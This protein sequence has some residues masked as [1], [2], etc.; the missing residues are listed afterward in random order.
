[1]KI[2]D[3][4]AFPLYD[5]ALEQDACGVGFV[6]HLDGSQS[7]EPLRE[8][9]FAL[10]HLEH[11]GARDAD[12]K[13]GDGAGVMFQVPQAFFRDEYRRLTGDD[14]GVHRMAVG[15]CFLPDAGTRS[16]SRSKAVIKQT[17]IDHG[18]S[19]FVW[20]TVPI[21]HDLL[22]DRAM[23]TL[24]EIEQVLL[25]IEP[26]LE[27]SDVERR[28]FLLRRDIESRLN[29]ARLQ[30][31]YIAS[32]SSRTIIYK[33]MLSASSLGDFYTDLRNGRMVSAFAI[34]HQRYSTNT[35]PSWSL[36]QPFRRVAHNGEINTLSGNRL[37]TKVRSA[38]LTGSSWHR[39][40]DLLDPILPEQTSDSANLDAILELM[41]LSER[42]L[43][44]SLAMLMPS[45][46]ESR[47][48]WPEDVRAFYQYHACIME[49]WD[50]PAA[51][52]FG[53]GKFVGACLDRHGLRP[54]R[55]KITHDNLIVLGSEVGLLDTHESRVVERGRL[56]P[57][58]MVVLDVTHG[59][60]YFDKDVKDTLAAARPYKAWL[61]AR[62]VHLDDV[63]SEKVSLLASVDAQD[64]TAR[65]AAFG[66]S[67]EEAKFIFEPMAIEGKEPVGSMG[68][69]TPLSILSH[70]PRVL[71][72]YVRQRFAQVTNPPIDS[73]RERS[74]MSLDVVIGPQLDWLAVDPEHARK[75]ILPSPFL[76]DRSLG[77]ITAH[78]A[79]AVSILET[80]FGLEESLDH[81]LIA[82]CQ[83]AQDRVLSG[84]K[85]LIL[86]DRHLV[87][88]HHVPIPPLLAIGAVHHHLCRAKL[89][90]KVSLIVQSGEPRD[91]HHM[92][93][94]LGF[95][96]SAVHPYL[97]HEI[98]AHQLS[99]EEH[100]PDALITT[101]NQVLDKGL[102]KVMAKMGISTL[103]SYC[104]AQ[105]FEIIGLSHDVVERCFTGAP[106]VLGGLAFE[107]IEQDARRRHGAGFEQENKRLQDQGMY[108]FRRGGE[109][110][111]WSPQMLKAIKKF[112]ASL[113]QEDYDHYAQAATQGPPNA[114]R[115]LLVWKRGI[116]AVPL[117]DVESVDAICA[118]FT[119]AAMSLGSLSPEAHRTLVRAMN[120]IGG[121]SNTGEGGEDPAYYSDGPRDAIARIK[122]IASGRFGVTTQYLM[123]AEEIEIK[124]AQGSKPGE[125]GQIP[126]HKVS[127]YIAGLRRSVP[128]QPLISPPPH[129]DIYSIED[130]AQLIDDLRQVNPG[131]RIGVKL[132]AERG[133]G[134][135]AAGVAKAGADVILISGHEGGTGASPLSSIK[136]AGSPWELGL[137]ET[138]QI[139][140]RNNLRGRVL[141]RTDGGLKTGRD[142]VI[143]ALLGAEEY[144]FGTAALVALGCRYVRQC[145]SNTCPVGIATQRE[146]L[147]E[148][149]D[150]D[151]DQLVAFLRS[152]AEHVRQILAYMGK[153]S[154]QEIIGRTDLLR[155]RPD[156]EHE[157]AALLD[158]KVLMP[159]PTKHQVIRRDPNYERFS[160][161]TLNER[162]VRDMAQAVDQARPAHAMYDIRN[163]DRT[164]GATLA[165]VIASRYG[166]T[167]TPGTI[168][169]TFKGC[170][171]QSFGAF[172]T[173][174]VRL[175][176]RGEAN[177]YVGKGMNGGEIIVG[178]NRPQHGEASPMLA[179][180]TILYG[181]TGGR[182]F[183][184]GRVGERF[185]VR[186]SG[187]MAVVEGVGAHACEYMTRG[188][189]A[190]LGPVGENFGAGMTG[191]MAYVL[192]ASDDLQ[193]SIHPDFVRMDA[194]SA[195]DE[196]ALFEM[197]SRHVHVTNSTR[198]KAILEDWAS[199][200]T[201]FCKISPVG[202]PDSLPLTI[203]PSRIVA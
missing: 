171:G 124:M 90:H 34:F 87:D 41:A 59:K 155:A 9:L 113:A 133:V 72:T 18:F 109:R 98:I 160:E 181:A 147:R 199:Y 111:G 70:L 44:H 192:N 173:E 40:R 132:V 190:I 188:Q 60:L 2:R 143:A 141:L 195:Q 200:R 91:V 112:R 77:A 123:H 19:S 93:T 117:E 175:V 185:A 134:T 187:A 149:Y 86:S 24:P 144:N 71:S 16:Y 56:G 84:A 182:L 13:T 37:W 139:L 33:G 196:R 3:S 136:N 46:W 66:Y 14:P 23:E 63:Q 100:A 163:T 29:E 203:L 115:D 97:A 130:L 169:L 15:M 39:S 27:E 69:D 135:I 194:L 140:V 161:P 127:A 191:G 159:R 197:I 42:S 81:A 78:Y 48:H 128:G 145:H 31:A 103:R 51:V 118:R 45:A 170:A 6:A 151:V 99:N 49:P 174:G 28:L 126:G 106:S 153:R 122:Q 129:H 142:I 94:L 121:K 96:A 131:A 22:G 4:K 5:A 65:Q 82:L 202:S 38:L 183:I 53:D 137:A 166:E 168:H 162:I 114:I 32:L 47:D 12:R 8:A 67:A 178:L 138:Q 21:R 1:M 110:H 61:D 35:F 54:A 74:G 172:L 17:L 10:S 198:G 184:A 26:W 154:L 79:G 88:Q 73:I 62:L 193:Q 55:Y 101:Y 125:G 68:D 158:L 20:R 7:C 64:L 179:G 120:I 58:Q 201:Q 156:L 102:L 148:R 107:H 116:N 11:R 25:L 95:G 186:N 50:G 119:S 83:S 157:R 92:A 177:D 167:M 164:V 180:N 85:V 57:G 43:P 108:R 76:H 189:V 176:L 150:G 36:A 80:V 52:V 30:S 75:F 105:L 152:L 146:D 89:R 165:G 104:G